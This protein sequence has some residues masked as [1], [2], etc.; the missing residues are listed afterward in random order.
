MHP[1]QQVPRNEVLGQVWPGCPFASAQGWSHMA[2]C[3]RT[4]LLAQLPGLYLYAQL[5]PIDILGEALPFALSLSFWQR[6]LAPQG[7]SPGALAGFW[8]EKKTVNSPSTPTPWESLSSS[9]SQ[10]GLPSGDSLSSCFRSKSVRETIA[11]TSW[12]NPLSEA[13]QKIESEGC[14]PAPTALW[15]S[16][17]FFLGQFLI[18]KCLYISLS[19]RASRTH[20]LVFLTIMKSCEAHLGKA[21]LCSFL[22][23][24]PSRAPRSKGPAPGALHGP[25]DLKG[26]GSG[27]SGGGAVLTDQK[28]REGE[29]RPAFFE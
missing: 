17:M 9:I 23:P 10:K 24:H 15:S 29:R 18:L 27:V 22:L 1:H 5:D 4:D 21:G 11:V 13:E 6:E 2:T 28:P 7:T 26:E 20:L 25:H 8:R 14:Y 3:L 12:N 19:L 16:C